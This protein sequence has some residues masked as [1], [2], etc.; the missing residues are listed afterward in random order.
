MNETI[1]LIDERMSMRRYAPR[2]IEPAHVDAIIHSALRAPTAGNMML[3]SIIQVDDRV[4][5]DKLAQTCGHSFIAKAPLVLLFLADM[6]RWYDYYQ[7]FEVPKFCD[8]R[9]IEFQTPK[10]SNLMMGCCDALIAAQTSVL[11]AE[12][13]GIG[14]CYIGDIMGH[15][16][17]HREMFQLPRWA[18]PITLVCYGY[19]PEDLERR[20]STRFDRRFICF[21]DTYKHLSGQ[22][23]REMLAGIEAKFADLLARK[24]LSLAELTYMNFTLGES[25]LEEK[26]SVAILLE[27]WIR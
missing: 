19:Y 25:E 3:Y 8:E 15:V 20:R 12:S 2:P 18:F 11:A 24:G 26:R 5:K 6:Q 16:E 21:Q 1:R 23:S 10:V 7:A 9:G 27:D 13:L 4:K 14:S 17:E 22:E